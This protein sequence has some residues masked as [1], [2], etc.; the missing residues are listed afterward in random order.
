MLLMSKFER[1]QNLLKHSNSDEIRGREHWDPDRKN[2]ESTEFAVPLLFL[3]DWHILTTCTLEQVQCHQFILTH[4]FV[5]I[6]KDFDR[7]LRTF[8]FLSEIHRRE[9]PTPKPTNELPFWQIKIDKAEP[10]RVKS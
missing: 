7:H 3:D 10:L 6:S 4:I 1:C 2:C 8:S 5:T 9:S